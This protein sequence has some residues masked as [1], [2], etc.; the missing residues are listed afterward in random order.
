[1]KRNAG[2][3]FGLALIIA[4]GIVGCKPKSYGDDIVANPQETGI[5][6][7][8]ETAVVFLTGNILSTLQPCGCSAGQLGGFSRRKV[9]LESVEKERRAAVDT[10]NM[11]AGSGEQDVIKLGIM[12]Q[13][14]SMLEYDAVNLDADEMEI[15]HELGFTEG[16]PFRILSNTSAAEAGYSTKLLVG[17]KSVRL[18][19]ATV[20]ARSLGTID[21]EAMFTGDELSLNVVI[22]DECSDDVLDEIGRAEIVDVVVCPTDA[23]E[24]RILGQKTRK[25]LVITVGRLGKYVGKLTVGFADDKELKLGYDKIPVNEDLKPDKALV[26]LYK[27]YQLIVEEEGLLA[28]VPRVPLPD[29]LKYLGSENCHSCHDEVN[30]KWANLKHAHAYETLEKVGS[31]KDPECVGCHVVGFGYESGFDLQKSPKK[32]KN[33]GCEVCHGPGSRHFKAVT[34]GDYDSDFGIS[35]PKIK[36]RECHTPDRSPGYQGHEKEY[37]Q[38]ISHWQEQKDKNTVKK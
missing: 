30:D 10:G 34:N 31:E 32:F 35:E 20:K 7:S 5:P 38:K 37:L 8:K 26:E 9:I 12:F 25:P 15:A 21:L 6:S 19:I 33:V 13:A 11:I 14:L 18:N 23:D 27:D 36:C 4:V 2:F 3:V 24:P 22:L 28:K 1:M 29:G 16:M 17:E